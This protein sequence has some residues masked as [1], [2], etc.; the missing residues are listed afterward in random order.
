VSDWPMAFVVAV[1][2][3]AMLMDIHIDI[4]WPK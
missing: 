3:V 1:I 2:A 4:R